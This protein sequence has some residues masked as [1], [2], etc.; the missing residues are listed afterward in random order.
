MRKINVKIL[1]IALLTAAIL[2]SCGVGR[3]VQDYGTHV[4]YAPAVNPLENHGGK[5]A[6]NVKGSISEGYFHRRAV[7]EVTP[8]LKFE[9]QEKVLPTV[10]LRGSRTT[11]AG[12]MINSDAAGAFDLNN[13]I[14]FR[15]EML[16]SELVVRARVYREG[17]EERATTLP[18]RKVADGIINTAEKVDLSELRVAFLPD[19]YEKETIHTE[20]AKLYFAYMRHDINPRLALNRDP[21]AMAKIENLRALIN[22]GWRIKSIDVNGWAS[23]EGEVAFNDKLAQ[24]RATAGER[25]L[26]D[27][28]RGLETAANA[29]IERPAFTVTGKGEDYDGFMSLLKASNLPERDAIANAINVSVNPAQR[30]RNVKALTVAYA[31][32]EKLLAPLRRAEFVISVFEPK[33]T[34]SEI[35]STATSDPSVLSLEELLYGATLTEDL[36]TKLAIYKA[37]QQLFPNDARAFNNAGAVNIK[38]GNAEAA[39][40]DLARANQL[41]PNNP[42]IQNNQ[43]VVAIHK[44]EMDNGRR[45]FSAS[46][47]FPDNMGVIHLREG[48]YPA[49]VTALAARTCTYNLAMS[50]LMAGNQQAALATL[51]CS[52]QTPKVLYMKAIIGARRND[53]AMLYD[54]LR[55]AV[56][57]DAQLKG[58]AAADREFLRFH[59]VP[60]FQ[61]IVR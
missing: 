10:T 22:K 34:D 21:E 16:V 47:L 49:A 20:K 60:E 32:V 41:A 37:G 58:K 40:T 27:L 31:E 19:R 23:P 28:F 61:A 17:R 6:A 45:L 59:N 46:G 15:P 5:V 9:G 13:V 48:N 26:T 53:T 18:E 7:L 35:L 8:V 38:L 29:T 3:M 25:F 51:Q 44:G 14:D 57:A 33:R 39:A 43:G 52:P 30:E 55:K 1:G 12:T 2:S 24:N 42:S 4:G 11:V 50:Q 36:N 54:N 56:A